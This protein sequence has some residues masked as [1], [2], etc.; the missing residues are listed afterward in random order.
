MWNVSWLCNKFCHKQSRE[1]SFNICNVEVCDYCVLNDYT[2]TNVC[3]DTLR[4]VVLFS[5]GLLSKILCK[6]WI[7]TRVHLLSRRKCYRWTVKRVECLLISI[8]INY[9]C[10]SSIR[11]FAEMTL[12]STNEFHA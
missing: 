5:L 7:R 11:K 6:V 1:K 10:S 2:V 9:S 4:N 12:N 3:S 8:Q